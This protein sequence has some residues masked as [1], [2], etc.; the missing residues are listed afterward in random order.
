M[1]N[2]WENNKTLRVLFR[3]APSTRFARELRITFGELCTSIKLFEFYFG[4][5]PQ[6]ASRVNME[7]TFASHSVLF[8]YNNLNRERSEITESY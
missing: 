5:R 1:Q 6:L 4:L 8:A 7:K 2:S 3:A